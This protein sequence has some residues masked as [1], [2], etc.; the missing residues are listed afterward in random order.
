MADMAPLTPIMPLFM[1]G[2]PHFARLAGIFQGLRAALALL[3]E[4]AGDP[5]PKLTAVS[6]GYA[7]PLPYSMRGY[8]VSLFSL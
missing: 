1:M 3:E 2:E 4:D 8:A 7:Q 5:P 6:G